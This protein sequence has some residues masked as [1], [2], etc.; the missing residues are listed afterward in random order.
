MFFRLRGLGA[1]LLWLVATPALCATAAQ[2]A[3]PWAVSDEPLDPAIHAGRLSNGLS[4]IIVHNA[5]PSGTATVRMR[6]AV[7]SLMESPGE[8]GIAHYLEHMAFNGSTH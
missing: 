8:Q 1:F 2:T 7:G 3:F 6:V 5:T 4:Y